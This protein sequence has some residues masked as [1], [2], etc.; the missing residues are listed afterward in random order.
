MLE[1]QRAGD[2]PDRQS[3]LSKMLWCSTVRLGRLAPETRAERE[4]YTGTV[5]H[6]TVQ[7]ER[8]W[9]PKW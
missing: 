6:E 1:V 9:C 7:N 8:D 2:C 4:H 5:L 3:V